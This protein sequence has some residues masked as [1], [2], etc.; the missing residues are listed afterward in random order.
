MKVTLIFPPQFEP[1]IPHAA[2]PCLTA[3]LRAAGHEVIQKD[4]NVESYNHFLTQSQ[5][6]KAFAKIQANYN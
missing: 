3:V 5:L 1:T 4:L 2:L 6:E